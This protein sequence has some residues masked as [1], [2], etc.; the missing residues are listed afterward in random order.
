MCAV[1]VEERTGDVYNL[2]AS[3]GKDK[4][5]LC[6]NLS[7][8]NSLEVLLVGKC[9]HRRNVLLVHNNRHTLLGL[10]DGKLRAVQTRILLRNLVQIDAKAR[11]QL[12]DGYGN[13]ARTEIVALLDEAAHLG[14]TEESL[15]LSLGGSITLLN[16]GTAGVDGLG[17]M[18]LGRSRCAAAAVA[19]GASAHQNDDVA[20]ITVFSLYVCAGSSAHNGTDLHALCNI[21]RMINLIDKAGGKTDLISVGAVAL[22][23]ARGELS[24]RKL[25]GQG[26]LQGRRR[27]SSAGDTHRLVNIAAARERIADCAA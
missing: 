26:R 7:D 24:L 22:R 16:L 25:T 15:E 21:V 10:G 8:R 18:L 23:S 27:V 13:T 20:G 4:S 5:G 9:K 2:L 14:T 3:P 12:A 17:G 19:A 1:G 6:R 11:C